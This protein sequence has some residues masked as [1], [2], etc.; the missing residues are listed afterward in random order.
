MVRR[1]DRHVSGMDDG[2]RTH[3]FQVSGEFYRGHKVTLI[4]L[5]LAFLF[6]LSEEPV[7]ISL[8][9]VLQ[10]IAPSSQLFPLPEIVPS[11]HAVLE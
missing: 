10:P 8:L 4:N 1:L 6:R 9:P 2:W 3:C 5:H 11:A 7:L